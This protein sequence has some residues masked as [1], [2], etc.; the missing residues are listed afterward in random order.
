MS[1]YRFGL[2]IG[3]IIVTFLRK[4]V[5]WRDV[6]SRFIPPS[7]SALIWRLMLNSLP[8]KDRLCRSRVL[9]GFS[10]QFC[11][12]NS[13]SVDHL[14]LYCPLAV[15]LWEVVYSAFQRRVSAE[16]WQSFFLQTM[17]VS[18][19][20]HVKILWKASIHAL[21]WGVW[22]AH[23]IWIFE[24]KSVDFRSILYLGRPSKAPVIKSVVWSPPTPGWIKVNTNGAAMG[25]PG[26]GGYGGIL[27]NCRAFVNAYFVIPL[28]LVFAF[29]AKLLAVWLTINFAWKYGWHWIWLESDSSYVVQL[30]SSRSEMVPW[31]FRQA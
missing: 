19:S 21:I 17:S 9:V 24:E 15:A 30:L 4:V 2:L 16:T 28:G 5:W 22:T 13:E 29:E 25:S 14:F 11:G 1:P 31:R 3:P 23:N 10:L 6:W 7:R 8:T 27:R 20:E 18:F 12:V 26:V